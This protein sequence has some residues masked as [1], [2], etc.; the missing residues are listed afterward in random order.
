MKV[1]YSQYHKC[2]TNISDKRMLSIMMNISRGWDTPWV[3]VHKFY[4]F[5]MNNLKIS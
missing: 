4:K 2:W 5:H 3:G 1:N